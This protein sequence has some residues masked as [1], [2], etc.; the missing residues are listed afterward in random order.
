MRILIRKNLIAHRKRNKLSSVIYSVTLGAVIFLIVAS[1][2]TL[3]QVTSESNE[4]KEADIYLEGFRIKSEDS[5]SQDDFLQ[6]NQT[7]PILL[8]YKD[9]IESFAYVTDSCANQQNSNSGFKASSLSKLTTAGHSGD[10][11]NGDV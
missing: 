9:K 11:L 7:D 1:T 8:E 10:K 5:N 2:I 6:P 4:F 3:M